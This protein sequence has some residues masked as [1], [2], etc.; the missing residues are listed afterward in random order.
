MTETTT[1]AGKEHTYSIA[2]FYQLRNGR[3]ASAKIYR[4]GSSTVVTADNPC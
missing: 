4:E 3:I 2:A 1:I